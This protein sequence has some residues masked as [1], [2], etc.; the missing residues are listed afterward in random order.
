MA[1]LHNSWGLRPLL[2]R[3]I[4]RSIVLLCA[5]YGVS[6]FL[7]L[8]AASFKLLDHV[9][10]SVTH[11]F[12][13]LYMITHSTFKLRRPAGD[14]LFQFNN[15]ELPQCYHFIRKIQPRVGLTEARAQARVAGRAKFWA[16]PKPYLSPTSGR[17]WVGLQS[18]T[19]ARPGTSLR[20][21]ALALRIERNA[22]TVVASYFT[23]PPSHTIHSLLRDAIATAPKSPKLASILHLIERIPGVSWPSSVPARD[24]RIQSRGVP[25]SEG[26]LESPHADFDATLGL[27]PI[28]AIYTAPWATPLP[29]TTVIL[30]KEGLVCATTKAVEDDCCNILC[31]ADSQAAL[32]GILST[33]P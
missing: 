24:Q 32:R 13:V 29:V 2:I 18:P 28:V 30:P 20:T 12:S 7:P 33:K 25:R 21:A 27:E 5:D 15:G 17:A 23:L 26:E 4:I 22:L 16:R 3:D 9:K 6:F 19:Q 14:A 8:P 31:V 11:R 10:K 1:L